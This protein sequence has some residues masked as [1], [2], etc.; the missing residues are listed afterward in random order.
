MRNFEG[1]KLKNLLVL[2]YLTT[3][4]GKWKRKGKLF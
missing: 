4:L 2:N 3:Q 1:N